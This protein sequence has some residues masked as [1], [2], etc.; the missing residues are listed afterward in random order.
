LELAVHGGARPGVAVLDGRRRLARLAVLRFWSLEQIAEPTG[1]SRDFAA[2]CGD[3]L[4]DA[5]HMKAGR[6]EA[7]ADID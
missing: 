3:G 5:D 6:G 4:S 1:R 2:V 7:A